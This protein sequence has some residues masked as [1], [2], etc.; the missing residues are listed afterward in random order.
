M[1]ARNPNAALTSVAAIACLVPAS[2]AA[3]VLP[4]EALR[5]G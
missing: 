1:A 2:R 5:D 4:S 3:R